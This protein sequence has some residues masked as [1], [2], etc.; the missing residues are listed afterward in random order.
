MQKLEK[1]LK[2]SVI[3]FFA[4]V[5]LLPLLTFHTEDSLVCLAENKKAEPLPKLSEYSLTDQALPQAWD[6]YFSDRIGLK[7]TC[8]RAKLTGFYRL[9]H[10]IEIPDYYLAEDGHVFC[11]TY[12]ILS[13]YCG[14][15]GLSADEQA[16]FCAA[17]DEIA[18]NA[19][20]RNV[21]VLFMP[22]SNKEQIYPELAPDS[23]HPSSGQSLMHSLRDSLIA[24]SSMPVVNA[25]AALIAHKNDGELL[26][27]RNIDPVHWNGY[28]AFWGYQALMETISKLDP[29]IS[30]LHPEDVEIKKEPCQDPLT[31]L[32]VRDIYPDLEDIRYTAIPKGGFHGASDKST[33][34][35]F[36]RAND[37]S[38][39]YHHWHNDEACND[40]TLLI[41]G[42][43]YLYGS[44][45][46][47]LSESFRDVYL[48]YY[49]YG[50]DVSQ[51]LFDLTSPDIVLLEAVERTFPN[52][53]RLREIVS[54]WQEVFRPR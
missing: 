20:E 5:L 17:F 12:S 53:E 31:Y 50:V 7:A 43:S 42:D 11:L 6:T 14:M 41:Y 28:G 35:E 9:F 3:V 54:E 2:Y 1:V 19:E 10:K 8:I 36:R 45:M 13:A 49:G 37:P 46:P 47:L 24:G 32:S 4:A 44:L 23:I 21:S 30:Y 25:D 52:T 22:I 29:S 34:A 18:R 33:P 51:E 27:Y 26:Y 40:K 39:V 38:D 16:E 15:N 48:L